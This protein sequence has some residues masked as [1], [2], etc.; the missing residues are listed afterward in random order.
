MLKILDYINLAKF[1]YKETARFVSSMLVSYSTDTNNVLHHFD[2]NTIK[3]QCNVTL[4]SVQND[5]A[6]C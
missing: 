1:F 6:R 2:L 3:C 5:V 4:N